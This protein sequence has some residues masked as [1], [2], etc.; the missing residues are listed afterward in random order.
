MTMTQK[1]T[2]WISHIGKEKDKNNTEEE[3]NTGDGRMTS[4]K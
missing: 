4:K 2:E 3:N 1:I